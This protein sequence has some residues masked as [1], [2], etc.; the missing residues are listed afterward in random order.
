M[1]LLR[2]L[3]SSVLVFTNLASDSSE[4]LIWRIARMRRLCEMIPR[5]TGRW[6]IDGLQKIR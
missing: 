2:Y 5:G 3:Y 6:M 1:G 4:G